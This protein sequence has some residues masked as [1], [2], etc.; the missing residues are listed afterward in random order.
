MSKQDSKKWFSPDK[1]DRVDSTS[2][3]VLLDKIKSGA[4]KLPGFQRG[5]AWKPEQIT[6]LW[7][8]ISKNFPIGSLML[9]DGRKYETGL[10]TREIISSL[11]P[12]CNNKERWLVLDGQQRCNAIALALVGQPQ[13]NIPVE[14]RL[15]IDIQPD[16]STFYLTTIAQPWGCGITESKKVIGRNILKTQYKDNPQSV[17]RKEHGAISTHCQ[18]YISEGNSDLF[19]HYPDPWID[20]MHTWPIDAGYP[21]PMDILLSLNEGSSYNHLMSLLPKALPEE[22][23]IKENEWGRGK[24]YSLKKKLLEYE[25]ALVKIPDEALQQQDQEEGIADLLNDVFIRINKQGTPL[26]EPELFFSSIKTRIKGAHD[27]VE[28]IHKDREAGR[29]LSSVQIMHAVARLTIS[30][31]NRS[32]E[33]NDL[34][35]I[36]LS[37]FRSLLKKDTEKNDGFLDKLEKRI[38]RGGDNPIIGGDKQSLHK[39]MRLV[40]DALQYKEKDNSTKES[41]DIDIGLPLPLLAQLNWR[42]WHTLCGWA[43]RYS[44]DKIDE[45]SRCAMIRYALM[46]HFF[47]YSRAEEGTKISFQ[48]ARIGGNSFP[49]EKIRNNLDEKEYLMSYAGNRDKRHKGILTPNEYAFYATGSENGNGQELLKNTMATQILQRERGL[50]FWSQRQWIHKWFNDLYDPLHYSRTDDEPFDRDHIVPYEWFLRINNGGTL[51]QN[52]YDL[53]DCIG[54]LRIWPAQLNRSEG[55]AALADRFLIGE[56]SQGELDDQYKFWKL[57]SKDQIRIASQFPLTDENNL[58]WL[59][60]KE[61]SDLSKSDKKSWTDERTEYFIRAVNMRRCRLYK[62]LYDTLFSF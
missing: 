14:C 2:I 24:H 30:Q 48:E 25:V 6:M 11:K 36:T 33:I 34:P 7:D 37:R 19:W 51:F 62:D 1:S 26:S 29:T 52:H 10:E 58:E 9:F 45:S 31:D 46:H 40:R 17:C 57:N 13:N 61:F 47:Y 56:D 49:F 44:M 15:W 35:R 38:A 12:T 16:N 27:Y 43:A 42:I 23:R 20:L 18:A 8:S 59:A 4:I 39:S 32:R 54:N 60:W 50:L 41:T 53:A 21:V 28:N 55:N 22:K 5:A 3:K